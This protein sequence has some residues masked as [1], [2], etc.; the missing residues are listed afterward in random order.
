MNAPPSALLATVALYGLTARR[1]EPHRSLEVLET[2]KKRDIQIKT[3]GFE[4]GEDRPKFAAKIPSREG[5]GW[6]NLGRKRFSLY[7]F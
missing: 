3:F 5:Q 2:T 7:Q 1:G 6:V 4:I